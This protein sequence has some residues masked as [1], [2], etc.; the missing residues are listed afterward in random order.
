[1]AKSPHSA[2]E[3]TKNNVANDEWTTVA[4][5]KPVLTKRPVI[6]TK[7]PLKDSRRD[8]SK[9]PKRSERA[10]TSEVSPPIAEQKARHCLLTVP[11]YASIA[12]ADYRRALNPG[13]CDN[14]IVGGSAPWEIRAWDQ[15]PHLGGP[16]GC[17]RRRESFEDGIQGPLP[18]WYK[19]PVW[20]VSPKRRDSE[21]EK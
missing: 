16:R 6:R 8:D 17:K 19:A 7:N 11:T 12:T 10:A 5:K 18:S 20:D 9:S 14:A 2:P 4:Y 1:M 13:P 3:T 21:M 15:K